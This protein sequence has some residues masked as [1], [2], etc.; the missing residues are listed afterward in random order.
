MI[1]GS[2]GT[3]S[4]SDLATVQGSRTGK[5]PEDRDGGIPKMARR[6][7]VQGRGGPGSV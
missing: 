7:I 3:C 1:Q 5:A 6:P 2:G 4:Q